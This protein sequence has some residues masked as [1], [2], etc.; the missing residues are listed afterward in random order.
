MVTSLTEFREIKFTNK[1]HLESKKG[2]LYE[3]ESPKD[4]KHMCFNEFNKK[5]LKKAKDLSL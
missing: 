2:F 5:I 3:S 1:L 4:Q